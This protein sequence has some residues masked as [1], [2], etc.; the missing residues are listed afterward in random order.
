MPMESIITITGEHL[1][2]EDVAS[3]ARG[4]RAVLAPYAET[5][6]TRS[7]EG[8][9]TLL[10]NGAIAYGIT[11]GFGAFKGRII[12]RHEVA[13]LQRNLV[14]SHAAGVGPALDTA[15][16]RA[17]I[18]IRANTLAMGYSGIRPMV[19][20]TLLELLNRGVTPVI[21]AYGSLG[22]SGDLAPLAHLA[23]VLIG[24]GEAWLEGERLLGGEALRRVGLEP[25]ELGA[26]EGLA[27][28]NG[29]AVTTA[30]GA[31]VLLRA[32]NLARTADIAGALSLEAMRGTAAAFDPRL[33]FVRPHPRQVDAA[34]YMRRVLAN[35]TFVRPHDP[36]D[37]QD[38]Y[39]LRCMPQVHGAVRD[40]VAYARWALE[41]ELNA[42]TD[43]PLIFF[44]EAG[45]PEVLSG[46]NFHAEPVGLA[47]DYLKLGMV[48]LGNISERRTARLVDESL[49][50]GLPPF[51][52]RHGG[53]E[54]GFMITQYTA[55]ALAS[56]NKVLA[57]PATADSIPTSAN[58][59]DHVSM[60]T[61][62]A[63]NAR[64]V[65]EN[66]ERILA[67]ELLAAAQGVDFRREQ[68]GPNAQLGKGT[69]AAY[70]L[71]RSRVPFQEHDAPLAPL[72]EAVVALIAD[73]ELVSSVDAAL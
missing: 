53:L 24:E 54:S 45:S 49:S 3:V 20:G 43:N 65:A 2:L 58:T 6:M 31:L 14:L 59:E 10:A 4:A 34:A 23:C 1:T 64:Q 44:D 22:A 17:V 15:T 32:E 26:K 42:V 33:H 21:P 27:L 71:L 38:A 29:T 63:H 68:L 7:W 61:N 60:A 41:I 73:G 36:R 57:H 40:T 5:T 25:V 70:T 13:A 66:V 67:V 9:Q 8:V 72:I 28:I 51:L 50:N 69:S 48:A 39:S 56:Q 12:P 46:G 19:V 37:I 52:T 30:I 62:A 18:A 55:A 16:V 35:S 11:T 47:L